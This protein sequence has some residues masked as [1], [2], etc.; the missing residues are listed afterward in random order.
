[1]GTSQTEPSQICL[2]NVS[3]T[4]RY[5]SKNLRTGI[6]D[7]SGNSGSVTA[8][9]FCRAVHCTYRTLN[10]SGCSAISLYSPTISAPWSIGR[11][12]YPSKYHSGKLVRTFGTCFSPPIPKVLSTITGIPLSW[13]IYIKGYIRALTEQRPATYL[14]DSRK[15]RDNKDRITYAFDIDSLCLLVN[16]SREI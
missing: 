2:E 6:H 10:S 15:I 13:A 9:P 3:A 5:P 12:R 4:Q 7:N 11:N 16:G 14:R 1:M 8:Y